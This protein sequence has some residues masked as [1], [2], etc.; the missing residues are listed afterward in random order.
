M[1]LYLNVKK[2]FSSLFWIVKTLSLK[3]ISHS[4][5]INF[6][7]HIVLFILCCFIWRCFIIYINTLIYYDFIIILVFIFLVVVAVYTFIFKWK[8]LWSK[9]LH[10]FFHFCFWLHLFVII[11][12]HTFFHLFEIC[13]N[14]YFFFFFGAIIH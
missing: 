11:S 13:T 8:V 6:F 2:I 10:K 4:F 9:C 5:C 12:L 3:F 7:L 14:Y 1:T